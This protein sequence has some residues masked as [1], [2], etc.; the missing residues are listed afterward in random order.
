MKKYA[1]EARDSASNKIVKSVVQAESEHAAARLLTDQGFVPLKIELEDDKS[2]V[3]DRILGRITSKDKIL[4]T[5]QLSTLIG[6]GLPLSQSMRT[7][8]EQTSNK[9]M[10]G[11]VQEAVV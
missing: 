4:F 1:Y 10:Q 2:N 11:I 7:V 9:R 5:R 8:L 6:A 3:I